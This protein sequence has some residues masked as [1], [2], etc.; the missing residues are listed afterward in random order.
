MNAIIVWVLALFKRAPANTEPPAQG[1][2]LAWG[3]KVNA[4]F[5]AAVLQLA[6][7]LGVNP[8]YLMAVIAFET[9]RTFSPSIKNFAGSGA[10]GLIQF[11]PKT[12]LGLGTSVEALAQMSAVQQLEWVRRYFEPYKGRMNTLSDVY[13]AVLYPRAIGK[14]DTYVLFQE[15][16]VAYRQ[17][18]GLDVNRDA[19]V[20][21]F[22]AA[23]KIY[24][25]L[26]EGK[27][28]KNRWVG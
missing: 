26:D 13:M 14:Q 27:L 12:A 6:D 2:T 5:R 21:K 1:I 8:D 19:K 9:G 18:A 16:T 22:E 15:G 7:Y 17:N 24:K 20:T 25:M 3:N 10:T 23:S 4:A 11:M 28:E